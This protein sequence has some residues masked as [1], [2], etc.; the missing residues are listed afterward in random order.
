[1]IRSHL[2]PALALVAVL[3][4]SSLPVDAAAVP[5]VA[6]SAPP[7]APTRHAVNDSAQPG[8]QYYPLVPDRHL[9]TRNGTGGISGPIGPSGSVA[10]QVAG[11]VGVP[12]AGAS[13]VAVN[14]TVVDTT[15]ASWLAVYPDGQAYPGTSTINWVAG[16]TRA[17]LTIVPLGSS[18][19]VRMLNLAGSTDVVLDVEGYF[20]TPQAADTSGL[21][22]PLT[23]ARLLD[24]RSGL[25]GPRTLGQQQ[26]AS[27]QVAG[28]G[29]VPATGVS[30]VILNVTA[31]N[32]T[33]ATY[34][35]AFPTGAPLPP[36][37]TV[38]LA[39]RQTSPNRVIV[40]LGTG[41]QV[42]LFNSSGQVDLIADVAAWFTDGSDSAASGGS[43]TPVAPFRV[44]DTR[45]GV[46]GTVSPNVMEPFQMEGL[47]GVPA[48][49]VSGVALNVTETGPTNGG[50]LAVFPDGNWLPLASDLN[51]VPGETHANATLVKLGS[52]GR[53]LLDT[54][55]GTVDVV[56]DVSGWF[57]SAPVPGPPPAAPAFTQ[58][59]A[60]GPFSVVLNWTPPGSSGGSQVVN[61]TISSSPDAGLWAVDPSAT[62]IEFGGLQCGVSY[63]FW[64]TASNGAGTGPPSAPTSVATSCSHIIGNVTYYRQVY[65]LSC[66]EAALQMA[67]SHES[68]YPS[69]AQELNDIGIDYRAGYY[70]GGVLRWGDPYAVFV[71]DPSGS[72]VALT[73]YGTYY[74]TI[75]SIAGR[76]G[77][78]VLRAGEGIAPQDVYDAVLHDHPVVTWVSFDWQYHGGAPWVAFDGRSLQWHGPIEHAVTIVG[79]TPTQVDVFNPWFGPQW[80]DK[81]TFEAAYSTF[82]SMA[83]V[84]A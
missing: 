5:P 68:I 65:E 64:I 31:T 36:T 34:V 10:V 44:L 62:R 11:H 79:V 13:A 39:P 80:V 66:E 77:G 69:Q 49:G 32:P 59:A 41:G 25:G 73:G 53:L 19:A 67:L 3:S 17:N 7:V 2:W 33:A 14:V 71:G 15:A 61:Y 43:F 42:S 47:G 38:N 55:S 4:C 57:S 58:G 20:A 40:K 23:P 51:F 6:P 22:R 30:A 56:A 1:M 16:E 50:W 28:R 76:Y 81:A 84:V 9:D 21:Y 48:S 75:A 63:T 74:T 78:Q 29:N 45:T 24:T 8:S 35:S 12:A 18:G 26:T 72:E 46:P 54:P 82:N 27:F 70:S 83:V 37:S 52:S 60:S